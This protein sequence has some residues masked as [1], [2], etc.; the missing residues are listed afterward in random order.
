MLKSPTKE[1]MLRFPDPPAGFYLACNGE[2]IPCTCT[3]SCAVRCKGEC[4]CPA[5][6]RLA[7]DIRAG[8]DGSRLE[9]L[10]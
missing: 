2:F 1:G 6:R 7:F 9:R 8:G 3:D 10:H 4:V 5:C